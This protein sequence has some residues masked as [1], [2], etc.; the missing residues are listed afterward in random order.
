MLAIILPFMACAPTSLLGGSG[1]DSA[2][3]AGGDTSTDTAGTSDTGDT[4]DTADT[5]D[6]EDTAWISD[7]ALY[8]NVGDSIAAGYDADDDGGY[9]WLL[10]RNLDDEYPEYEG[11]D[12]WAAA[13]ASVKHIADSGAT[14]TE[15]LDNLRDADLPSASGPVVV[16]IS[17]GGN[18]FNDDPATMISEDAT[19]EMGERY[20]DNLSDMVDVLR[21]RYDDVTIYVMNVQD[22]TDGEG[23]IPP[24]YDEGMCELLQTY[25]AIFGDTAVANLGIFNEAIADAVDAEGA[26]LL[27]YH[28]LFYGHGL[29]SGDG[30][31]SDDCAHPTQEGHHQIRRLAWEAWTGESF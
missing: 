29:N 23:T 10:Y 2:D 5:A 25:G 11:H 6:T 19:R 1:G 22:P 14:S 18:D 20:A 21:D 8:L 4:E 16:T 31:M 17:A 7:V 30:W 3:S 27:D 24:G 9:G 12:L 28:G 26:L 15:I 13:G